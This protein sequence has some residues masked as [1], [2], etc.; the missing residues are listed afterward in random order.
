MIAVFSD[1]HGNAAALRE[2]LPRMEAAE[3]IFC[4]G[5][6]VGYRRHP[7]AAVR[8][9]RETCHEVLQGNHDAAA[10]GAFP[11][12]LEMIPSW[13]GATLQDV[14]E[15]PQELWEWLAALRP[16]A[17]WGDLEAVHGTFRDPLMEFLEPGT[18]AQEHLREQSGRVSLAG[19]THLPL[20]ISSGGVFYPSPQTP[21]L[22]LGRSAWALN[23]G[24]LGIQSSQ[25]SWLEL[26]DDMARWHFL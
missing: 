18:V 7:E 25:Q 24:S 11:E 2:A 26:H 9:V 6:T 23:P 1:L 14:E 13:L 5:D 17:T 12:F 19:H 20:A 10:T 4:L 15:L 22:H 3:K 21:E 8:L 16:Q